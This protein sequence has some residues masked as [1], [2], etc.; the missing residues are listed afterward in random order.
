[1]VWLVGAICM[2]VF[3]SVLGVIGLS[4]GMFVWAI[5]GAILVLTGIFLLASYRSSGGWPQRRD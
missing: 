4:L 3:G 2:I 5:L 1:M